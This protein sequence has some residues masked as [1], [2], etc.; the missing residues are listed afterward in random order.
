MGRFH[1]ALRFTCLVLLLDTISHAK[2]WHGI[3]PL[4]STRKEVLR[5][6]GPAAGLS[7]SVYELENEVV[8]ITYSVG[9]CSEGGN[10]NVPRDVV[11]RISVTPKRTFL[12]NQLQLNFN[13]FQRVPDQSLP[14]TVYY[15]DAQQGIQIQTQ[16]NL[17]MA[18]DYLPT[19]K[20]ENLH[21]ARQRVGLVTKDGSLIDSHTLFDSYGSIPFDEEKAHLDYF[22]RQLKGRINTKGY[23]AVHKG[24]KTSI[25]QAVARAKQARRY[26]TTHYRIKHSRIEIV[27]GEQREELAL[28]LYLVFTP[29]K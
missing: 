11:T 20:E 28:D 17:V 6:L 13:D 7:S 29:P 4:H 3:L 21:C 8:L 2:E 10:W 16:D 19:A 14:G 18:I 27:N 25:K 9:T 23:I 26:L 5:I 15:T 1:K 12:L 24:S 22:G